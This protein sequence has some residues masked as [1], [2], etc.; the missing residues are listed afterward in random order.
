MTP[1]EVEMGLIVDLITMA[2]KKGSYLPAD[3][4]DEWARVYAAAELRRR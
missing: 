2:L 4:D 3:C 1:D